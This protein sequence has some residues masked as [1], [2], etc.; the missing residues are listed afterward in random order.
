MAY[1]GIK[2]GVIGIKL[3]SF[4]AYYANLY[5]ETSHATCDALVAIFRSCFGILFILGWDTTS[6][7]HV[8]PPFLPAT[9]VIQ[10]LQQILSQE[11]TFNWYYQVD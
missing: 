11:Y 10:Q 7:I 4:K 1:V 3:S 5:M 9:D 8:P 2:H 6:N